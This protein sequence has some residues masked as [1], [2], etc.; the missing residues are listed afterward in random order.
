MTVQ[1]QQDTHRGSFFIAEDG[2]KLAEMAYSKAG[3]H[4]LI[5]A[6]T[7]VSEV[8]RG[9]SAGKAMLMQLVAYA[10]ENHLKVVPLCPFAKSVF[11]KDERIRDVL[12]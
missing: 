7:E 5:I 10:R 9:K 1:H 6:H 12:R 3:E 4:I 2:R 8:L 11:D